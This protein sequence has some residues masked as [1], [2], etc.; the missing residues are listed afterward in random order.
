MLCTGQ[1][2]KAAYFGTKMFTT[3]LQPK[4]YATIQEITADRFT[5]P[6]PLGPIE[7]IHRWM[8]QSVIE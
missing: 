7:A 6:V 4:E 3:T 2:K 8:G 5:V 1:L